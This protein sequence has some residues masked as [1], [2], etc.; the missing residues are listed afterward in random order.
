M[1]KA[2]M[3][4][5]V[6]LIQCFQNSIAGHNGASRDQMISQLLTCQIH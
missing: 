1:G 2:G 4:R 5:E 3:Q 6:S